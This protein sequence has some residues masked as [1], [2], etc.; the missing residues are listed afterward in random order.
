M[1]EEPIHLSNYSGHNKVQIACDKSWTEPEWGG[2]MGMT[3]IPNVYR[4][5]DKR[6]YTYSRRLT[7]CKVCIECTPQP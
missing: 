7:T 2:K 1:S 4:S 6:L 3:D 5:D